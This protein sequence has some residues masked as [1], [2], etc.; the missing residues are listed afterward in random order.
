M[1]ASKT[2]N[3]FFQSPFNRQ[4]LL[5]KI[6]LNNANVCN[7]PC[8]HNQSLA[9]DEHEVNNFLIING[10]NDYIIVVIVRRRQTG[11]NNDRAL[12]TWICTVAPLIQHLR[13][14]LGLVP[15]L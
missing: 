10:H 8:S 9:G 15:V 4:I 14:L 11:K 5:S 2:C 1:V 12:Q 7:L 6:L 3:N 13:T